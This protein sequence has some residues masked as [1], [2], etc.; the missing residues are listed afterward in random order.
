MGAYYFLTSILPPLPVSL[1]DK[2]V[3]SFAEISRMARRHI[4]PADD[5]LLKAQLSVIDAANWENMEQE[6]DYFLEGGNLTQEE[7]QKR[8]NIPNFIR[9]FLQEKER[10][11]RRAYTGDRLWDLCYGSI[12]ERAEEEG[13]RYLID[14]TVWEVELRNRMIALRLRESEKNAADYTIRP[15]NRSFDFTALVSQLDNQRNLL[16][17]ERVLDVARLKQIFHCQGADPFSLDA[18]LA[19]ISRAFIYSRWEKLMMRYDIH[20]FLYG[21]G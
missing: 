19:F 3:T 11:I 5:L 9:I 12:L 17:K 15:S 13:C 2:L 20:N 7:M 16:D 8:Q 4:H 1:G 14:Y 10:G 18:I 6:R 21:G